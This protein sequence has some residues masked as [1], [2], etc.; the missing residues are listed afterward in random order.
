[1]C[2]WMQACSLCPEN[3]A[4][5]RL[6]YGVGALEWLMGDKDVTDQTKLHVQILIDGIN[7]W[8]V[9]SAAGDLSRR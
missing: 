9:A 4:V 5:L 1:M 6:Q 3:L 7:K 2:G 8:D